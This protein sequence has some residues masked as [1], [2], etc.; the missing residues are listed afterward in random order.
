MFAKRRLLYNMHAAR[1]AI[2]KDERAV[3]VEGYFDVIRLVAAGIESTV[4]GLGTSLT[5]E[6]AAALAK[7]T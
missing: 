3:V 1:N 2:R 6:H 4:A 5:E 7:L